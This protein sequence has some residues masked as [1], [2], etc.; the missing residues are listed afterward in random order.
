[1]RHISMASEVF[2][3]SSGLYMLVIWLLGLPPLTFFKRI[4]WKHWTGHI[5]LFFIILG[6]VIS[7]ILYVL[8]L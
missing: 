8:H 6:A 2:I 7:F 4:S 3:I 5:L 1:M